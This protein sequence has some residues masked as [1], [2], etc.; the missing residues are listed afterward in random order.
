M[1]KYNWLRSERAFTLQLLHPVLFEGVLPSRIPPPLIA[2][3]KSHVGDE[4]LDQ[5][6]IR[7][8]NRTICQMEEADPR[9]LPRNPEE[10]VRC[11][12]LSIGGKLLLF[13]ILSKTVLHRCRA[14]ER[15]K[16]F[17]CSYCCSRNPNIKN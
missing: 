16:R 17:V 13:Q 15:R 2:T 1:Y 14:R 3:L 9:K 5:H 8:T 7:D 4:Y 12:F 11:S 6:G 10:F